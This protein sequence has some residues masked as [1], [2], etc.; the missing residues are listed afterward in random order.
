MR[1]EQE[2]VRINRYLAQCGVASRRH[3]EDLIRQGRVRINGEVVAGL[4]ARV[5]PGVDVVEVDGR[6][7]VPEDERVVVLLNKPRGVVTTAQD[8][9][10]R[11]TVVEL[12]DLP[13]RL[14]PVGRLDIDTEGA[15]LLTNDGDLAFRLAHPRFG[16]EKV[17]HAV[18]DRP[19]SAE[20]LEHLQRGVMIDSGMTSP[21]RARTLGDPRRVEVVLHEGKKR[22]VRK[23][24]RA[25]GYQV[26][27]LRRVAIGP[28][29]LGSLPP[30]K[31]RLLSAE[32]IRALRREVGLE[33]KPEESA[34]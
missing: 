11:P 7:V 30:G 24:F 27:E 31:W 26:V 18:L 2:T 4:G 28:I 19:I 20:D 32:E 25:L 23:M 34:A 1:G 33:V 14:F 15:L 13:Q 8:D 10:G 12:V 3:A 16:V 17:Y 22:Q 29:E 5:R 6:V 21:C 9:R